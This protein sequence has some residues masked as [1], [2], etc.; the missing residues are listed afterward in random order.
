MIK[1]IL[2]GE[3]QT[4]SG[5]KLRFVLKIFGYGLLIHLLFTII[6]VLL[7]KY[8]LI[9]FKTHPT[10]DLIQAT[11]SPLKLLVIGFLS[12]FLHPLMEELSFR[13]MLKPKGYNSV[14]GIGCC[15]AFLI[16]QFSQVYQLL[17]IN[18]EVAFDLLF[19]VITGATAIMLIYYK[20]GKER[21]NSIIEKNKALFIL[22]ANVL[23]GLI[24]IYVVSEPNYS[25]L[26]IVLLLPYVLVGY[27]KTYALL[28]LGFVYAVLCHSLNNLFFVTL[29]LLF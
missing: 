23:F 22:I 27:L 17:P 14:I 3:S 18:Q 7:S 26:Y 29:N 28:K 19:V 20:S 9:E 1:F 10:T 25:I 4:Y 11:N 13:L 15:I 12:V 8:G 24:H 2:T 5:N 16:L 6:N 21:V